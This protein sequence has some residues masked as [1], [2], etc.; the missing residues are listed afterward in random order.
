MPRLS[1]IAPPPYGASAQFPSPAIDSQHAPVPLGGSRYACAGTGWPS[2][3][4]Q[5]DPGS[6]HIVANAPRLS[7][8]DTFLN[9]HT[10]DS[11]RPRIRSPLR[12][13]IDDTVAQAHQ[14]PSHINEHPAY[15]SSRLAVPLSRGGAASA[16]RTPPAEAWPSYLRQRELASHS[17]PSIPEARPPVRNIPDQTRKQVANATVKDFRQLLPR[18]RSLPFHKPARLLENGSSSPQPASSFPEDRPTSTSPKHIEQAPQSRSPSAGT[19]RAVPDPAAHYVPKENDC[20]AANRESTELRN[21]KLVGK[22]KR[23]EPDISIRAGTR[24]VK[25]RA[26]APE[27]AMPAKKKNK[28]KNLSAVRSD[29]NPREAQAQKVDEAKGGPTKQ[30]RGINPTRKDRNSK[31]RKAPSNKTSIPRHKGASKKGTPPGTTCTGS[32][33]D[34][35]GPPIP[36]SGGKETTTTILVPEHMLRQLDAISYKILDQ[37]EADIGAEGVDPG[38]GA[39]FYVDR[40]MAARRDFWYDALQGSEAGSLIVA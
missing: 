38:A 29:Q 9:G 22:R 37:Y 23:E 30:K 15:L 10:L 13:T 17:T 36:D 33:T 28:E 7:P 6:S 16:P 19:A 3:P 20:A 18:P 8:Y 2:I 21:G 12:H 40:L 11:Y 4:P 32:Q 1:S 26:K 31:I 35:S 14:A 24:S 25:S 34:S 27:S 39:Q 5:T